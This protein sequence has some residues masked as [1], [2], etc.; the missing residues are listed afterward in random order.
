MWIDNSAAY[1]S[2]RRV[3]FV[4]RG[5]INRA[6]VGRLSITVQSWSCDAHGVRVTRVTVPEC[7]E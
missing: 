5:T 7:I 2:M 1:A 3:G 6:G 4:F